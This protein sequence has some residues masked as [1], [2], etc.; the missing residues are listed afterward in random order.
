[1]HI[2]LGTTELPI[3]KKLY[4]AFLL[5]P[6]QMCSFLKTIIMKT[7]ELDNSVGKSEKFSFKKSSAMHRH[8]VAKTCY[9]Q[10]TERLNQKLI[11]A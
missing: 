7:A 3:Y 4:I 8:H 6:L 1:M 11:I 2:F 9:E 10:N 5:I